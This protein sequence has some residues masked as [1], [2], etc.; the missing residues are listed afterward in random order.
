ME[1][2]QVLNRRQNE[3]VELVVQSDN[4]IESHHFTRTFP[5]AYSLKYNENGSNNFRRF[6]RK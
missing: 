6:V 3:I 2:I 1:F 4:V 5:D